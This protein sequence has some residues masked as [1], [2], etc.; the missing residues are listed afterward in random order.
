[1]PR[2]I[3]ALRRP[4]RR[5]NVVGWLF[6]RRAL[7]IAIGVALLLG[8]GGGA[9]WLRHIGAAT[10][11]RDA[12]DDARIAALDWSARQGLRI[13]NIEV[14]GRTQ[15]AARDVMLAIEARRGT[16]ILAI[17]IAAAR[18][19]LERLPWVQSA[20]I[21]RRLPAS[22]NIRLIERRPLALWQRHGRFSVLDTE[23]KEIR[24][25]DP[26]AFRHLLTVIGDDAPG[27]AATLIATIAAAPELK[28]RV[29]Y[30]QR[31]NQRRWNLVLEDGLEILLP[32]E[33]AGG[34]IA[35]LAAAERRDAILSRHLAVIDLRLPDRM[36]LRSARAAEPILP[37]PP[38][39][40]AR[41]QPPT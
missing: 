39:P 8:L 6:T 12:L 28:T 23:G 5:W 30:A 19:E 21:E 35:R 40:R 33:D 16:P 3:L 36:V 13:E 37:P 29:A 34:A 26:G 22:L 4:R 14:V 17:D 11:A 38:A 2:V 15:T 9:M 18:A 24:N 27:H 20:T 41:P 10:M 31:V 1:M 25:A 7:L 32:E